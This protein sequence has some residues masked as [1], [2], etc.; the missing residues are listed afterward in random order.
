VAGPGLGRIQLGGEAARL[1]GSAAG[2]P[3]QMLPY[4][5]PEIAVLVPHG[6]TL[7]DVP[8][9][10]FAQERPGIR[11]RS[12]RSP[13]R[14]SAEDTLLDVCAEMTEGDAINLLISAVQSRRV[15]VP[16]L[17]R[18][19]AARSRVRHRHLL[20]SLLIP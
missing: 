8:P 7:G 19:M 6:T 15:A 11:T 1:G 18:R 17:R 9:W 16:A 3:H 13:P 20:E 2:Y 12:V 5:P 14:T 4:P 10:R